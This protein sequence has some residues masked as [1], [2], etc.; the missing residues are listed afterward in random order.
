MARP[1]SI[2]VNIFLAEAENIAL[3]YSTDLWSLSIRR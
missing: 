2:A 1:F 3:N